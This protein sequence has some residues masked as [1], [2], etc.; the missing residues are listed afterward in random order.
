MH[1]FAVASHAAAEHF[2]RETA[3]EHV[4]AKWNRFADKNML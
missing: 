1:P 2:C 3:L 4:P